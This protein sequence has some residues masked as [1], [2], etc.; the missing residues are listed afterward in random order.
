VVIPPAYAQVNLHY[1]SSQ[2]PFG[3]EVT[4]GIDTSAFVGDI[5]A[6]TNAIDTAYA[7]SGIAALHDNDIA[8]KVIHVKEGP[9]ITGAAY[10]K[11]VNY[12]GSAGSGGVS[13]ATA[14]LVHKLTALGGHAGKGRL[15]LPG[16]IKS[17]MDDDGTIHSG[18]VT[19]VSAA[20]NTFRSSLSTANLPPVLLHGASSPISI[21]TPILSFACDGKAATQRRRMRR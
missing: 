7:A 21:P 10:D 1:Q 17:A 5:V 19:S 3:A 18:T 15:Y 8:L 12:P 9:N 4:L 2:L 13:P 11:N 20:F 14:Y 6:M 16:V